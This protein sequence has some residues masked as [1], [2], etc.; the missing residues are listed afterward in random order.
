[1]KTKFVLGCLALATAVHAQDNCVLQERSVSQ[2]QVVIQER[3]PVRRDVVLTA[4]GNK[5]CLVDFR[6]RIGANW[7]TAFGEYIWPG[8]VHSSEACAIA[9]VR[10]EDAV[11]QQVGRSQTMTERTLVCKDRPELNTIRSAQVGTVGDIGQFRPHPQYNERFWHNGAQCRWFIDSVFRSRDVQ[12]FQGVI[13]EIQPTRWVVV[14][15][16]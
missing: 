9:V 13:C 3:S 11:R 12:T 6:V 1:M 8:D 7:H 5:K 15:K 4:Q 10:A 2:S 16:F 14:D